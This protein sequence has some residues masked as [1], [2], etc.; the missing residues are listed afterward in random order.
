MVNAA[1]ATIATAYVAAF[2]VSQVLER[3]AR[4]FMQFLHDF[5]TWAKKEKA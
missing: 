2:V 1:L 4:R 5:R 3:S